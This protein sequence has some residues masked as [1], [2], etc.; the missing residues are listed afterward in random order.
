MMRVWVER[1]PGI[2]SFGIAFDWQDEG[3]RL[4]FAFLRWVFVVEV[5]HA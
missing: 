2:V 1:T 5:D 3:Y 4:H